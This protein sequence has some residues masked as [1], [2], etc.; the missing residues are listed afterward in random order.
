MCRYKG[1]TILNILLAEDDKNLGAIIKIELEEDNHTVDLVHDGIEAVLH[2]IDKSYQFILLDIVM[3]NL[4]G[5]NA[6]RII[7]RLDPGV[8]IIAFSGNAGSNQVEES[9]NSG[10]IMCL[11]KPFSMIELK[12]YI[13]KHTVKKR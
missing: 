6:L 12:D 5:I 7:K 4:D 10:A 13:K 1:Q 8:P 11:I 2:C 3:P 9:C